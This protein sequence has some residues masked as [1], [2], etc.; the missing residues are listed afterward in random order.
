MASKAEYIKEVQA[1]VLSAVPN[2]NIKYIKHQ[3]DLCY[4]YN[5]KAPV[6]AQAIIEDLN[7][8]NNIHLENPQ[9]N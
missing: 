2:G 9:F 6:T 3:A 1:I 4:G 8:P 7:D 5:V